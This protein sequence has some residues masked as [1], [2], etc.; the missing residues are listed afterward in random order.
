MYIA[1]HQ[2]TPYIADRLRVHILQVWV[3]AVTMA[4]L[5]AAVAAMYSLMEPAFAQELTFSQTDDGGRVHYMINTA[6]GDVLSTSHQLQA[7]TPTEKQL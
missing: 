4:S 5:L 2:Y 6:A 1:N 7:R 3:F